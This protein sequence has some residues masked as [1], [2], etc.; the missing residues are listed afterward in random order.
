MAVVYLA[1]RAVDLFSAMRAA[2]LEPKRVRMVH[3]FMDADASLVLVEGVKGGRSGVK[4]LP[5]LMVYDDGKNY[6]AEVAAMIAGDGATC[7]LRQEN[8]SGL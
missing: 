5:P 8:S 4:I 1:E 7:G 3:S 6:S 2:R